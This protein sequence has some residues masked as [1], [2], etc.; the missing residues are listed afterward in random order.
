MTNSPITRFEEFLLKG[1][2]RADSEP[3]KWATR[4]VY[5]VL[6]VA[7]LSYGVVFLRTFSPRAFDRALFFVL[8]AVAF[9]TINAYQSLVR[10]LSGK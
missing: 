8:A 9:R 4:F 10:K 3:M 7:T 2:L 1:A 6:F 5:A